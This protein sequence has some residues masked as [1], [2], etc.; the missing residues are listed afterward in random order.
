MFIYQCLDLCMI[1]NTKFILNGLDMILVD[2]LVEI[3]IIYFVNANFAVLLGLNIW[4]G[5][6]E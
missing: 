2:H 6:K 5:R 4:E 3:V 1:M